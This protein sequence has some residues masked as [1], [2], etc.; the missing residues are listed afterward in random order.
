MPKEF[1][2][3]GK[4]VRVPTPQESGL[5][6]NPVGNVILGAKIEELER[7]VRI[8]ARKNVLRLE[9]E[10]IAQG[11]D[12]RLDTA[13][14]VS[15]L[16]VT[17]SKKSGKTFLDQEEPLIPSLRYGIRKDGVEINY[18][19][20]RFTRHGIFRE[21]GVGRHRKKGS[22]AATKARRQWISSILPAAVEELADIIEQKYADI[23]EAN[24]RF[25]IPGIIDITIKR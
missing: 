13:R 14:G 1:N 2:I 21:I 19:A 15:R 9:Q 4:T 25:L 20:F 7:E 8:W 18:V 3:D 5:F 24:L 6:G 23:A 17:K 16:R 12:Q 10:L 22:P 11:L